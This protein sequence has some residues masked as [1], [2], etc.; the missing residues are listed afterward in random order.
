MKN[1]PST[2]SGFKDLLMNWNLPG[3]S[4]ARIYELPDHCSKCMPPTPLQSDQECDGDTCKCSL[5]DDPNFE[6]PH[7]RPIDEFKL[8]NV[9]G[10][11]CAQCFEFRFEFRFEF[12][13][14]FCF[15]KTSDLFSS[16]TLVHLLQFFFPSFLLFSSDTSQCQIIW[17]L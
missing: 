1:D 16:F 4:R 5:K 17:K 12:C 8:L 6:C 13:F 7:Y 2:V 10:E 3:D 11:L 15:K 9:H 14:E